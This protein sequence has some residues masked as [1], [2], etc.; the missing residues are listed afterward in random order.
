MRAQGRAEQAKLRNVGA[1]RDA[2]HPGQR[3]VAWCGYVQHQPQHDP[4]EPLAGHVV[5]EVGRQDCDQHHQQAERQVQR[6]RGEIGRQ[7]RQRFLV[8]AHEG[9]PQS[10]EGRHAAHYDA[11]TPSPSGREPG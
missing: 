6:Q 11:I 3:D 4:E 10:A 1:G 8:Q 7:Q 9:H 5:L 2:G